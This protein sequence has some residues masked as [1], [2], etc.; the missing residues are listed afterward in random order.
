MCSYLWNQFLLARDRG[1]NGLL[2]PRRRKPTAARMHR[3]CCHTNSKGTALWLILLISQLTK[4]KCYA[5]HF[6][7]TFTPLH[8]RGVR[9]QDVMLRVL[10]LLWQIQISVEAAASSSSSSPTCLWSALLCSSSDREPRASISGSR[11][12]LVY[13]LQNCL[14]LLCVSAMRKHSGLL[15]MFWEVP[16]LLSWLVGLKNEELIIRTP[17][18]AK[19]SKF[20][21]DGVKSV[22]WHH[23]RRFSQQSVQEIWGWRRLR[24]GKPHSL[25][26]TADID[27]IQQISWH[28]YF[29][30]WWSGWKWTK[31]FIFI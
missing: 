20:S 19:L 28:V 12:L 21:C 15:F 18:Q 14:L 9:S 17:G 6:Q 3:S 30:I 8:P 25:Y 5:R 4:I 2:W 27:D 29:L 26:Y 1:R 16:P 24:K 22:I 31:T 7:V 10:T 23:W 11:L 13:Q